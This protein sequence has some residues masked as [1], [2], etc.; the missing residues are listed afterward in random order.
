MKYLCEKCNYE[1]PSKS[2][3]VK[4]CNTILHKTGFRKTL[5]ENINNCTECNFKS[6]NKHN[7]KLHILN[8]HG[9]KTDRENGFK[10]YCNEC[11]F[12]VN[13]EQLMTRHNNTNKHKQKIGEY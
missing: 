6:T 4:H 11:D 5:C 7:L 3:F 10:Y 13:V 12:G 9:S 1:T 2:S 8:K